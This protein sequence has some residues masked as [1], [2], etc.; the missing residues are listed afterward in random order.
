MAFIWGINN[1]DN[2]KNFDP[3]QMVKMGQSFPAGGSRIQNQA[4]FG[5]AAL[6][7]SL[8]AALKTEQPVYPL[9]N[10]DKSLSL[11]FDG[12]IIN[13]G[14]LKEFLL[15][16][17]HVFSH[18]EEQGEAVL[19][20]FEENKEEGFK[21]LN[22]MFAFAIWDNKAKELTLARDRYGIRPLYYYDDG[23]SVIFAS[24]IKA[25]LSIRGA[26]RRLNQ[27]A[28]CDYLSLNYIPFNQTIFEG[29]EKV[30]V[31]SYMKFSRQCKLARYYWDFQAEPE[32]PINEE[33]VREELGHRLKEAV[34]DLLPS[35]YTPGVFLSGGLDS[36]AIAYFLRELRQDQI[37]TFGISFKEKA[38]D[39]AEYARKIAEWLDLKHHVVQLDS[40]F[41]EEY[42]KIITCYENLH[43]ETSMIPFYYLAENVAQY[44]NCML[45]GES[46][47]ELLGG[48]PELLADK[49][50]FYYKRIPSLFRDSLLKFLVDMLPV[51]DAP[52][53][54]DYKAKH[55]IRGA[56][57]DPVGAHYY[58]RTVFTEDEKSKL[59][60]RDFY[61][62]VKYS[63]DR[64]R[65]CRERV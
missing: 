52:V 31:R 10:E 2:D 1:Y 35:Q 19:H 60:D 62:S 63:E 25:I 50:L 20:L 37:E 8:T 56:Q 6:G 46:G 7:Q 65:S 48:Y 45:C 16:K 28:F 24:Q 13:Y 42:E 43:A 40:R 4:N 58:W 39:E 54:F 30:P 15:N 36:G 22:G 51:S 33:Q 59:L 12:F 49:L 53:G 29:I 5:V 57:Q 32:L 17:G 9:Q 55:F 64:K 3:G 18:Q 38:Y 34:A 14:E 23:K 44:K 41:V 27:Q 61:N 26:G 21:L 11:V 47:D